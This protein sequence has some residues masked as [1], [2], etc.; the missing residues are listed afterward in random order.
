MRIIGISAFNVDVPVKIPKK[1]AAK[2]YD[3]LPSTVIKIETDTGLIGW[4]QVCPIGTIYEYEHAAGVRA[5]FEEMCPGLIGE[6]PTQIGV[7]WERMNALLLGSMYAK[8]AIDIACW[9]LMGKAYG[10]PTYQLIGGKLQEK[11]RCYCDV[12]YG[13]AD[14]VPEKIAE[15]R[16]RGY[17]H[18]Q[19]KVGRG[20]PLELDIARIRL[21]A[22]NLRPGETFVV[23]ANKSWKTHQALRVL[24][25]TEAIDFYIEQPCNTY[26]ECLSIRRDVR[27]PMILDECIGDVRMLL[28]ALRDDSF[29]GLGC[30]IVR[31]GGIT[32]LCQV[33][34]ICAAAGKF[35]TCDDSWGSDLSVAATTH[36]A[37][38][39]PASVFFSTYISSDF[40]T[41]SYDP[42]AAVFKDGFIQPLDLPGLG[43]VPNESLFGRPLMQFS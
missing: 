41:L 2:T 21:A 26:E 13:P 28:R 35:M 18:F 25:A 9:D 27:Q 31:M 23:D 11:A 12:A 16:E 7:I 20:G 19:I 34:D 42:D 29:E 22:E 24:R 5:A 37:T 10:K 3:A 32:G 6:D 43:V 40:S 17:T 36:V 39:T 4:S 33:R 1:F 15:F 30:K 14:N 38:A 8:S